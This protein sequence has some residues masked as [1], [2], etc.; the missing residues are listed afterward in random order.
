MQGKC[1]GGPLD[2]QHKAHDERYFEVYDL[3]DLP[4][5]RVISPTEAETDMSKVRTHRYEWQG[6][7]W[8]HK[9]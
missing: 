4:P 9:P 6:A 2:G 7:R 1:V 5:I 3:A 8:Q